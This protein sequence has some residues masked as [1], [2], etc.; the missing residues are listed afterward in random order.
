MFP[1]AKNNNKKGTLPAKAS[2]PRHIER[3]ASFLGTVDSAGTLGRRPSV[4]APSS[5]PA[6]TYNI[7]K[8]VVNEKKAKRYYKNLNVL[9]FRSA[10]LQAYSAALFC[11]ALRKFQAL[12][13]HS[14]H[15]T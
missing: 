9:L 14:I 8:Q 15:S 4:A 10:A 11:V 6:D 7:F 2:C 13:T 1:F 12:F 5:S 3:V